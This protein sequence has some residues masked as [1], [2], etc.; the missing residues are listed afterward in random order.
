MVSGVLIDEVL[1]K[2]VQDV[3][4]NRGRLIVVDVIGNTLKAHSN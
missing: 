3:P 2:M 4:G 1:S